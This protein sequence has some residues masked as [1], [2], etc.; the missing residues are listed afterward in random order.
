MDS[1]TFQASKECNLDVLIKGVDTLKNSQFDQ[2][3]Y[4]LGDGSDKLRLLIGYDPVAAQVNAD[5]F[6]GIDRSGLAGSSQASSGDLTQANAQAT[7]AAQAAAR[8][9]Q[10]EM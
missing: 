10:M 9:A 2:V 3:G 5:Y 8:S 7:A 1:A 4:Q 6:A